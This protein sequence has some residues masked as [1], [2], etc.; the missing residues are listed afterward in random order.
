MEIGAALAR[1]DPSQFGHSRWYTRI[2][3]PRSRLRESLVLKLQLPPRSSDGRLP[4]T[5]ET[6]A[7]DTVV[8]AKAT[9]AALKETMVII[10]LFLVKMEV[11]VAQSQPSRDPSVNYEANKRNVSCWNLGQSLQP[12]WIG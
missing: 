10:G 6:Y 5:V 8:A 11:Q 1:F 12:A 7:V 2:F 4:K 9:T 3:S